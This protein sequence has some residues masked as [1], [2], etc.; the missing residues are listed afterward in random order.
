MKNCEWT[1]FSRDV[2]TVLTH[3][4]STSV[5][6]RRKWM[7]T[8]IQVWWFSVT[9]LIMIQGFSVKW[10]CR[11]ITL[12][13][14]PQ[15]TSSI[16]WGGSP[17]AMDCCEGGPFRVRPLPSAREAVY[18]WLWLEPGAISIFWNRC[19]CSLVRFRF[20]K[21]AVAPLLDCFYLQTFYLRY[22]SARAQTTHWFIWFLSKY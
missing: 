5:I 22:Q 3:C 17:H 14:G 9:F 12:I 4:T 15:W 1:T 19:G 11:S 16:P 6:S 8:H 20:N 13:C 21:I 18:E 7:A 2:C 10:C